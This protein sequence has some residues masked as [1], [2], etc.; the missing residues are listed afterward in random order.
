[1]TGKRGNESAFPLIEMLD[2]NKEINIMKTQEEF[3]LAAL[4][5]QSE[6][7]TTVS[8]IRSR[9]ER[10]WYKTRELYFHLLAKP[11]YGGI[12]LLLV[13]LN[14]PMRLLED[15]IIR[16]DSVDRLQEHNA[17]FSPEWEL[18]GSNV[19]LS[20]RDEALGN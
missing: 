15:W 1:V 13:T 2:T 11:F 4:A 18:N 9:C 19:E 20:R 10:E 12:R 7:R 17:Y 14:Y 6:K 3:T 8:H 5:R 16:R